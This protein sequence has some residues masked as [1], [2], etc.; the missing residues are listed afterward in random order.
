M[1]DV[2]RENDIGKKVAEERATA[3]EEDILD[4][5]RPIE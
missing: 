3:D 2:S 1:E 4:E 5:A